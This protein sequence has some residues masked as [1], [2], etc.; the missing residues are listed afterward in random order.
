M[1]KPREG[2]TMTDTAIDMTAAPNKHK[3]NYYVEAPAQGRAIQAPAGAGAEFSLTLFGQG[4]QRI[5][6]NFLRLRKNERS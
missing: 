6:S 2:R 3:G 1:R 4:E 5:G